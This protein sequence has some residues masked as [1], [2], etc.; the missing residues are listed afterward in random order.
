MTAWWQQGVISQSASANGIQL[1]PETEDHM[2]TFYHAPRSRSGRIMW[3]LEELGAD[4]TIRYTDIVYGD[5]SG[6]RDPGNVHPDGKVPAIKHDGVVV[7]ESLAIA[8]YLTELLPEAGLGAL[9]G[10]P[11][12]G[13][14]LTWM[15]WLTGEM[16]P[17]YMA[18]MFS[19]GL[20][21][22][23]QTVFDG[24]VAR[25]FDALW[26]KPY[27]TGDRFTAVDLMVGGMLIFGRAHTPDNAAL[28]DWLARIET[29]PARE[30]ALAKDAQPVPA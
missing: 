15:S 8:L 27:L 2:L 5:G 25:V 18:K 29:R 12:R 30:R 14:Y 19:P 6:Q 21:A 3:L 16:E 1:Q 7:T 23:Q 10:D 24:V 20:D 26:D 13:T 11:D 4:Y 22:R 28:D 9:P 17:I